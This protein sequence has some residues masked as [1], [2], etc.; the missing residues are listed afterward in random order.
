MD[1]KFKRICNEH[2][3]ASKSIIPNITVEE[4]QTHYESQYRIFKKKS[5][6]TVDRIVHIPD[7]CILA[8]RVA[9]IIE[10]EF[11]FLVKTPEEAS[12]YFE[13]LKGLQRDY[14]RHLYTTIDYQ[15]CIMPQIIHSNLFYVENAEQDNSEIRKYD[16][17]SAYISALTDNRLPMPCG[18]VKILHFE[19]G[20]Q[21]FD[22]FMSNYKADTRLIES[23]FA[24]IKALV[25]LP[26]N[27]P[28]NVGLPFFALTPQR[29][30]N[31]DSSFLRQVFNKKF[32]FWF[33]I[34]GRPD[35][36]LEQF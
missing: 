9:P 31:T 20:Q 15:R 27:N 34:K 3:G 18:R 6:G 25:Y 19:Q 36:S 26:K 5:V 7:C 10:S 13:K 22:E 2:S 1:G 17:K 28:T 14:A 33:K 21:W 23:T 29:C 4:L 24:A 30:L 8:T 35:I 11:L 12:K 32:I 16:L